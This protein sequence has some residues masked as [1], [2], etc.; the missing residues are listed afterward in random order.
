METT[1]NSNY[2]NTAQ[3]FGI[4]GIMVLAMLVFSPVM[5]LL[6]KLV[7]EEFSMFVYYL[8]A[9]GVPLLIV[10]TIR[11]RK[12]QIHS[13]NFSIENPRIIP[14][15][16]L[17]AMALLFGVVSPIAGSIPMPDFLKEAFMKLGGQTG[18]FSFIL[19]VIA[20]PILEELIFRGIILD[21]L[22]KN[23]SPWKSI[24]LSS[25]LFGLV[26]LNPWQFITG[27]VIGIF[28][29]WIYYNTRS[30]KYA[31]LI[32]AAAN[33]TGFITRLFLKDSDIDMDASVLEMYGNGT[34]LVLV[35]GG[36]I[37]VLLLCLYFL[38]NEFKNDS[39]REIINGSSSEL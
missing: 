26:H 17:G 22:L 12:T 20:A 24:L 35:I 13:F 37:L 25:F 32:H 30:V 38:K 33:S 14:F 8:L 1:K 2:P 16:I 15:V 29:G 23:Y 10:Y 28:A 7:D 6:N 21:G 34:N 9:V 27:M 18:V 31:I 5:I 39:T 19:M 36:S 11:Q 4:T 3:S